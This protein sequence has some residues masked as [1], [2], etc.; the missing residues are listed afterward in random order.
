[1]LDKYEGFRVTESEIRI[2]KGLVEGLNQ[3]QIAER[4]GILRQSVKNRL[5][6]LYGR[7]RN[8]LGIENANE[9]TA[10]TLLLSM[11]LIDLENALPHKE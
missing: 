7:M 8:E 1:M 11:D 9:I 5:S 2:V 4:H 10:I 3:P 6:G